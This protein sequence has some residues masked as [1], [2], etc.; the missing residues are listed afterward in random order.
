MKNNGQ[1]HV[2]YCEMRANSLHPNEQLP[3]PNPLRFLPSQALC[4]E[5][6]HALKA[7]ALLLLL[8]LLPVLAFPPPFPVLFTALSPP[9]LAPIS[10]PTL[11]PMTPRGTVTAITAITCLL[12]TSPSP[13]DS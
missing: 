10:P 11:M 8:L 5:L 3:L 9:L 4:P 7:P 6:L 12:Y 13:R 1:H 2:L